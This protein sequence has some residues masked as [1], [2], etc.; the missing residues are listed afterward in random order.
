MSMGAFSELLSKGNQIPP[1][2][3]KKVNP[4]EPDFHIYTADGKFYKQVEIVE[5]MHWGR[6]R[7]NEDIAPL[8]RNKYLDEYNRCQIRVWY[9]FIKNINRK[10]TKNYGGNCWL[11]IY[12][13]I[14]VNHISDVGFWIN[15][16]VHMKDEFVKR[17]LINFDKSTYEK[18]FVMNSGFTEL[19]MI[20]PEDKVIFSEDAQYFIKNH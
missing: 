10:F 14:S 15:I 2:Y 13:N 20:Y 6:K 1:V 18:I 12:H 3:F 17:G 4:P 19:V 5:N 7:G 8:D 11:V 16:I 9:T